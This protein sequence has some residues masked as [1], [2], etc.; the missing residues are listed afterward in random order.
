MCEQLQ[1][2][3]HNIYYIAA[4]ILFY[5]IAHETAALRFAEDFAR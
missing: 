4:F 2:I 3:K 1:K 5:S